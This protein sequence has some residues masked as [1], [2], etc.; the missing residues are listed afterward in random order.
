M[1]EILVADQASR[2]IDALMQDKLVSSMFEGLDVRELSWLFS[3]KPENS[4]FWYDHQ[5]KSCRNATFADVPWPV[6]FFLGCIHKKHR[7]TSRG[8]PQSSEVVDSIAAAVDKFKWRCHFAGDSR[9][10]LH[11]SLRYRRRTQPFAGT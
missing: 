10:P 5:T 1:E 3:K 8:I 6:I 11:K 9:K 2:D 7:Y 4:V